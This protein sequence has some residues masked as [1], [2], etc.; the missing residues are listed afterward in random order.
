MCETVDDGQDLKSG[1]CTCTYVYHCQNSV[2]LKTFYGI[3]SNNPVRLQH[4]ID[5]Q[6]CHRQRRLG[7]SCW[8][9]LV[10]SVGTV[11]S[12]YRAS[13]DL[14]LS[15]Y[16]DGA[17]NGIGLLDVHWALFATLRKAT[18][19]FVCLVRPSARPHETTLLPLDGFHEIVI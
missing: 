12:L 1:G 10:A 6:L 17:V 11:P 8:S 4:V 18:I 7:S 9:E 5:Q 3:S 13:L 16:T 19:S 14:Y 15:V 2:E